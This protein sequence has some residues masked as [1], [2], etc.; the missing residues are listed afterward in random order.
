MSTEPVTLVDHAPARTS[1][2]T[3]FGAGV[4]AVLML[5]LYVPLVAIPLGLIGLAFLAIG[6]LAGARRAL[7][8]SLGVLFFAAMVAGG[9]GTPPELVLLSVAGAIVAFDV[10]ENGITVGEQLGR[11]AAT[12][13][14][15]AV[16]AA[17]SVVVG[18]FGAALGAATFRAV[19]DGHPVVGVLLLLTG[20]VVFGWLYRR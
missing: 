10:G 12:S 6:L 5:T 15:E 16:H 4:F 11:D 14:G 3:A 19:G 2:I 8:I 9:F 1:T 7:G 18:V 20:I 13:R 17:G